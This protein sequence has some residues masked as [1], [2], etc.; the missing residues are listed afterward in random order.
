MLFVE[1]LQIPSAMATAQHAQD[2]HQQQQPLGVAHLTVFATFRQGLQKGDQ[3]SIG[4][5]L[6]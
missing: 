2:C 4:N 5:G 1:T 6:D 3:I